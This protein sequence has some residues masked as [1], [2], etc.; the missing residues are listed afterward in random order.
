MLAVLPRRRP[1]PVGA[2]APAL[3]RAL[4]RMPSHARLQ[5]THA[6]VFAVHSLHPYIEFFPQLM[7]PKGSLPS[8]LPLGS[9]LT[10]MSR[11]GD[12]RLLPGH[13]AC[14]P[15][16]TPVLRSDFSKMQM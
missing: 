4:P 11:D 9:G 3:P 1:F 16:L 10:A 15:H 12:S 6:G 5:T 13:P 8:S 7:R 14:L 2:P